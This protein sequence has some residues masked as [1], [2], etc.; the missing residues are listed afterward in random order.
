MLVS[1]ARMM[2]RGLQELPLVLLGVI[3]V[4]SNGGGGNSDC[5]DGDG[6][7]GSDMVVVVFSA[8]IVI[9]RNHIRICPDE[10]KS[11]FYEW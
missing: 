10:Q 7:S 8:G 6:G 11:C 3:E 5:S 1:T 9:D 4:R 2:K